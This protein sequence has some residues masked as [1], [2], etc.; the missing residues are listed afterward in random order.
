MGIYIIFFRG[1]NLFI[2]IVGNWE[3]SLNF[4]INGENFIYVANK[5]LKSRSII[6]LNK[7]KVS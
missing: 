5:S 6:L 4:V 1:F 7:T 2:L 3:M